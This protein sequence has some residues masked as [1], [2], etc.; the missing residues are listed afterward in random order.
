MKKI[1]LT[2]MTALFM[3][4]CD[5]GGTTDKATPTTPTISSSYNVD[6]EVSQSAI[7]KDCEIGKTFRCR[8]YNNEAFY[9]QTKSFDFNTTAYAFLTFTDI[10]QGNLTYSI[11]VLETT[12]GI[13][14]VKKS[15]T[16]YFTTKQVENDEIPDRKI[17]LYSQDICD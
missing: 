14:V 4:G 13:D 17:T 7:D 3:I 10:P 5:E 2:L 6:I 9:M 16:D 11:D 1:T 12:G 15:T 8:V